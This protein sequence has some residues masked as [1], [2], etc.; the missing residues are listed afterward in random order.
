MKTD[1]KIERLTESRLSDVQWLIKKV[2]QTNISLEKLRHKYRTSVY[3]PHEYVCMM[4]YVDEQIIGF[5]GVIPMQFEGKNETFFLGQTCDS[6]THPDYQGKGVHYQLAKAS[7]ELLEKAGFKGVYAFHSDNTFHSCKKLGWSEWPRFLRA[8]K[9]ISVSL[10]WFKLFSKYTVLSTLKKRNVKRALSDVKQVNDFKN[11][12]KEV[13]LSGAVYSSDFVKYKNRFDCFLIQLGTCHLWLKLDS[14]VHVTAISH[15]ND[16][17]FEEVM[18]GLESLA[19][20][21]KTNEIIFQIYP[22]HPAFKLLENRLEWLESFRIGYFPF[23]EHVFG[24]V[25]HNYIDMDSVI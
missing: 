20:R 19:R 24:E 17:N 25:H 1:F 18:T 8:H 7:Y 4:A 3:L 12:A 5:Y 11:P 14:V 10:P 21:L 13:N 16:R 23:G 6:F 22:S 15:I 2:Y 9:K